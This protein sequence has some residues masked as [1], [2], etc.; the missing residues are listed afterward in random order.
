MPRCK[1][2]EK[3][4]QRK[5][6][7]RTKIKQIIEA[8]E[9]ETE[10]KI[11]RAL[12]KE[13]LTFSQMIKETKLSRGTVN[14]YLKRLR[15][16]GVVYKMINGENREVYSLAKIPKYIV[17]QDLATSFLHHSLEN[18]PVEVFNQ[19]LGSLAMFLIKEDKTNLLETIFKQLKAYITPIK[20][21]W[22]DYRP[23]QIETKEWEIWK[24]ALEGNY[25]EEREF[26]LN[27][28]TTVKKEVILFDKFAEK[29]LKREGV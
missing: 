23:P 11:L 19:K 4:E 13:P 12:N 18:E 27:K 5:E 3:E 15:Q 1:K 2:Q 24:D 26:P 16:R 6:K 9:R 17:F 10:D 29:W 28:A 20:T 7:I 22:I 8:N 21:E 14:K 25:V